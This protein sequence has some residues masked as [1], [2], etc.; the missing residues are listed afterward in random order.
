MS[1]NI[2][3]E[4]RY[5]TR[6]IDGRCIKCLAEQEYG[7]CLR[8]LLRGGREGKKLEDT[9]TGL[10]SFLQSPDLKKLRDDSE[11]Y[12]SE[13]KNVRIVLHLEGSKSKYEMRVD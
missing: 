11:W 4:P 9:Y 10:V 3:L 6:E 12:L 2:E 13:G 8:E 5:S 7:K 1:D